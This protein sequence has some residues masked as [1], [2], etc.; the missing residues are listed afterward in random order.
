MWVDF[1]EHIKMICKGCFLQ[2]Q[3][4]CQIRQYLTHE[5]A[6]FASNAMLVVVWTI[7]TLCLEVC[8]V[9]IYT[10]CS[11]FNIRLHALS[12]IKE[13]M[14][15]S[16]PSILKR[17]YWLQHFF[18]TFLH[19]HSP[20]YFGYLSTSAPTESGLVILTVNTCQFLLSTFHSTS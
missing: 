15:M 12:L 19:S 2:I 5:V 18:Y 14:F 9:L 11:V 3:D 13:S 1:A 16:H 10:S 8:H 6:A 4:I 7:V 20:S 17:L